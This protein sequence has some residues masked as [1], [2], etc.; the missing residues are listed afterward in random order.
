ME[1]SSVRNSNVL[2]GSAD[3][4]AMPLVTYVDLH[5]GNLGI[6][7][8][9][10]NQRTPKSLLADF[11]PECRTILPTVQPVVPNALP[12]YLVPPISII[13]HLQQTDPT[14]MEVQPHL[15]ILDL[16]NGQYL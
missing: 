1:A 10:L 4:N 13:E 7:L 12:P 5:S 15:V 8:P 11:H 14:F 6:G 3:T 2:Y 9:T 16:G